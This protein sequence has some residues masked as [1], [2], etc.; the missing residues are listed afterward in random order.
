MKTKI[1]KKSGY[2]ELVLDEPCDEVQFGKGVLAGMTQFDDINCWLVSDMRLSNFIQ[3][4]P[5]TASISADDYCSTLKPENP[6]QRS[7]VLK[8]LREYQEM[9]DGTLVWCTFNKMVVGKTHIN[10]NCPASRY[11]FH[12]PI[13]HSKKDG[14][15][16]LR[17]LQSFWN[18][19]Q[20]TLRESKVT[21]PRL[22]KNASLI[23]MEYR[24]HEL[25]QKIKNE[26]QGPANCF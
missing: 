4:T 7:F 24:A 11:G 20:G 16:I 18:E 19:Y 12:P 1:I 14:L 6:I 9:D 17:A 5:Y 21:Y 22:Q 25:R 8:H 3:C 10:G 26:E 15:E 2:I 23:L 13:F